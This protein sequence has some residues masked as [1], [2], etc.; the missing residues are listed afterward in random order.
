MII[1]LRSVGICGIIALEGVRYMV[2]L[3]AIVAVLI[4]GPHCARMDDVICIRNI[5]LRDWGGMI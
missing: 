5:F 2:P 4:M 1:M 3:L